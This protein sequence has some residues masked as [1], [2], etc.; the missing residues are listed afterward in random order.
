M[1]AAVFNSSG[2]R[3]QVHDLEKE[4]TDDL[5]HHIAICEDID[6]L[7]F[8]LIRTSSPVPSDV[9]A[10]VPAGLP[11]GSQPQAIEHLKTY[12]SECGGDAGNHGFDAIS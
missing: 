4:L 3:R 6:T 11:S 2:K 12:I 8:S 10:D 5:E 7:I 9:P 1:E